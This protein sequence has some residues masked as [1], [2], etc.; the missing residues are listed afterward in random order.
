MVEDTVVRVAVC[1][2]AGLLAVGWATADPPAVPHGVA[3]APV[4][5]PSAV[6]CASASCHGGAQPDRVGGEYTAWAAPADPAAPHDPHARAY[7]V[8]F[9]DDSARIS[10]LL[11]RVP[12]HRDALCLKCHA[13]PDGE[14]GPAAAEGVACAACHGP[15]EKWLAAHYQPGWKA[16]SRR[17]KW[18]E[19]GFVP[20]KNLVARA[21]TC[22]ACHV[23]AAD[24]EVN[25][26]LLAAGHPRLTFEFARA[27]FAP[28]YRKH[29]RERTPQ[30]AFEVR[31]WVVGQVAGLRAT[32]DLLRARAERADAPWPEFA[33][34]S[35]Y[36]CHQS[37]GGEP[38]A[39]GAAA[40]RL[41]RPG[42]EVWHTAAAGVA[43]RHGGAVFPGVERAGTHR[44]GELQ[45][46]MGRPNPPRK[47]AAAAAAEA[48]A[49]LDRW[50]AVAQTAE[51]RADGVPL[52]PEIPR[53]LV[54]A[55][56]GNAVTTA[57]RVTDSDWDFLAAHYLGCGAAYH[58]AGGRA[59]HPEWS[60]PLA[61]L[62]ADL[63]FPP[64]VGGRRSDSPAGF[65]RAKLTAVGREFGR[66]RG[67][68]GGTQR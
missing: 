44:V 34:F 2:T 1:L 36:A 58:A 22:T 66:L 48:V 35:C 18:D 19:Y 50:L 8:L 27:H 41:G 43:L 54:Q 45:A 39:T 37:I 64:P 28:G 40:G 60:E 26:D 7:R 16:L 53:E 42:W 12:A 51:D 25:H 32:A 21:V 13:V 30:P 31:A 38:R 6:S 62:A 67:D 23:G 14:P 15:A 61:G 4:I 63:R 11:G 29:W 20:T 49:E 3:P 55:L 52:P 10:R 47:E 68:L 57:G 5:R 46:L 65:D 9:N 59:A 56:A 24:R 33:G 17:Q